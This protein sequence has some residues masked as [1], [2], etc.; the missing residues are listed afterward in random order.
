[1]LE[2]D[3]PMGLES[4]IPDAPLQVSSAVFSEHWNLLV[5]IHTVGQNLISPRSGRRLGVPTVSMRHVNT[6]AHVL[7]LDAVYILAGW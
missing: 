4:K 3:L 2:S 5:V 6:A 1:M 7:L